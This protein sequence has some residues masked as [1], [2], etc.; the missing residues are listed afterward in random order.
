MDTTDRD[1]LELLRCPRTGERLRLRDGLL[2]TERG[3]HAYPVREG[4]CVL[5]TDT[6]VE[7]G[8]PPKQG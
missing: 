6:P 8:T 2:V 3:L 7:E 4:V 5:L 1:F